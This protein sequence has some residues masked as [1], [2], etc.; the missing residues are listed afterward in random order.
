MGPKYA[1][2]PLVTSVSGAVLQRVEASLEF[3]KELSNIAMES[4]MMKRAKRRVVDDHEIRPL[5]SQQA[6]SMATNAPSANPR[7]H[8]HARCDVHLQ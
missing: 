8:K 2:I 6:A 5:P 4:K 1:R 7:P 3:L